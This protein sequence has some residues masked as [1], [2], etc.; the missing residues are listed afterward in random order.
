V[1]RY[2]RNKIKL[3]SPAKINLY[4]NILGKYRD[5]VTGK[6]THYH[7]I[8]SI[9]ERI[10]LCDK[11]EL[12]R[13]DSDTIEFICTQK[14]IETD[15]NLCVKAAK[16]IFDR[17]GIKDG[18]KI[19]LTKNIPVGAGLGGGSSNAAAVLTGINR[20]FSLNYS[21]DDLFQ[22][23][24]RLGSDVNFFIADT[25]YAVVRG[26]GERIEPFDGAK[27][28]HFLVWPGE[29]LS[30]ADV[31]K[32]VSDKLTNHLSNVNII[33]HAIYNGDIVLLKNNIYNALEDSA[34]ALCVPMGELR[35]VFERS[36]ELVKVTGSGSAIYTISRS[37]IPRDFMRKLSPGYRVFRVNTL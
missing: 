1:K 25:Q 4:L 7:E 14:E 16:L 26:R 36:G 34:L 11:I 15:D 10:S 6:L 24:S 8:E 32:N 23:G 9:F 29:I 17:A 30:T 31:Y 3:L 21:K 12:S 22:L 28:Y 33:R 20:M 35:K 2:Y 5:P 18:I 19:K 37:P 13:T 27:F